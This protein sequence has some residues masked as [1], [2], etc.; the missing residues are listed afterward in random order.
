MVRSCN[1]MLYWSPKRKREKE[2]DSGNVKKLMGK[3]F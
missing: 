1:H 2:R 3:E